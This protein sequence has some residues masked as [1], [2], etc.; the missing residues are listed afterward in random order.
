[1]SSSMTDILKQWRHLNTEIYT[2]GIS[3]RY[4]RKGAWDTSFLTA[5]RRG[6]TFFVWTFSLQNC[7]KRYICG[8]S[9]SICDTL[10]WQPEQTNT[11][12]ISDTKVYTKKGSLAFQRLPHRSLCKY[13]LPFGPNPWLDLEMQTPMSLQKRKSG[14]FYDTIQSC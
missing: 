11:S 9:H 7:E 12:F 13:L 10:L 5:L 1:M 6:G 3:C 4:N 2:E 14:N 8:L